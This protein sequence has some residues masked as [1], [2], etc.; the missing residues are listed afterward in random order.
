MNGTNKAKKF[1]KQSLMAIPNLIYA[2]NTDVKSK[3]RLSPIEFSNRHHFKHWASS[4]E[5]WY[6]TGVLR[7]SL[8]KQPIGFE[9]TF[10][11]IKT[12]F[13]SMVLHTAITDVEKKVFYNK[14]LVLPFNPLPLFRESENIV[15]ALGNSL[16]FNKTSNSFKIKINQRKL[17]IKLNLEIQDIMKQGKNGIMAM[18]NYPHD[19]SYYF[20]FP[21]LKTEGNIVFKDKAFPV[22]G[23]AWCDHQWG[24]FHIRNLAWDWFSL[25][26]DNENI[27]I[28]I[29]NFKKKGSYKE[30][31]VNITTCN[32]YTNS[33]TT[34]LKNIKIKAKHIF[35]TRGG[36]E[37]PIGWII[38]IYDNKDR[39]LLTPIMI[40]DINPLTEDQ[41]IFSYI[42][43][44]YWEGVCKVNGKILK[45][46]KNNKSV[47]LGKKELKGYAYV[48]LVG[49]E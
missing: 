46:V 38:E 35:K 18:K 30:K 31:T 12:L 11:R 13:E 44:S 36:I 20:S 2:I 27:Y 7:S 21:N 6:F 45:D 37:Y 8:R 4:V 39:T 42:M 16:N 40:F 43:P 14:E 32:L 28:M 41:H 33:K 9:I 1:I 17:K 3:I 19:F 49:Y 10:F 25:R 23:Y 26:F 24:N 29:F 47:L 48:E 15:H 5:W 34:Q 22:S